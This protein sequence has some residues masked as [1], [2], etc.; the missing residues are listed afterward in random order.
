ME[1]NSQQ[2]L[3]VDQAT[4]WAAL[5][6]IDL[7]KQSIPGCE[8]LV[9]TGENAFEVG[10]LA[11]VGPVKARFKGR[12]NIEDAN[13]P[14]AY[15][16]RFDGQGGA[17]GFG[18]GH[19]RVELVPDGSQTLLKYTATAQVGGKIAQIGSRLVDM[20]AQK[21]AGQFFDKFS[22][23][24]VERYPQA[25]ATAAGAAPGAGAGAG[26]SDTAGTSA[27]D[28]SAGEGHADASESGTDAASGKSASWLQR[29]RGQGRA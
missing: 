17:A 25:A 24:L 14:H 26:S 21:M 22:A 23:A 4:A 18:K 27:G 20:A 5:N 1:M 19:A 7:L 9:S 8:S 13:P 29:L 16:I 10:L 11:A 3:P 15:T 28:A 6:D 2:L 12:M